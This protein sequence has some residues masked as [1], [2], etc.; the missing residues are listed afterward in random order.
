MWQC[1]VATILTIL[2]C[3]R[4]PAGLLY[5]HVGGCVRMFKKVIADITCRLGYENEVLIQLLV[6]CSVKSETLI[7]KQRGCSAESLGFL[8]DL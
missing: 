7:C 8:Q 2:C 3:C 4:M 6:P 5:F 1:E